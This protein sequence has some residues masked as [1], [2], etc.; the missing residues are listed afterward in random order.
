MKITIQSLSSVALLSTVLLLKSAQVSAQ[1]KIGSNPATITSN[2]NLEVEATNGSKTVI[3]KNNGFIGVNT[4]APTALVDINTGTTTNGLLLGKADK[5]TAVNLSADG[6]VTIKRVGASQATA[7]HIGGFLNLTGM[8]NSDGWRLAQYESFL[9]LAP[10]NANSMATFPFYVHNNG[11][12]SMGTSEKYNTSQL[13]V[14]GKISA[15]GYGTRNGTGGTLQSNSFNIS[16][17]DS[18][19]TLW[20]DN[21]P[22]GVITTTAS[23][24]RL[25]KNVSTIATPALA[26]VKQLRPVNFEYKDIEGDIFKSDNIHHEGFIAHELQ[27]VIPSAVNGEKDALTVDGKIQPQSVNAVPIVAILTQAIQELEAKVAK[28]ETEN[29]QLKTTVSSLNSISNKITELETKLASLN[30]SFSDSEDKLSK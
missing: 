10:L 4:T 20:I 5:S 21:T 12:I 22:L 19:G 3:S 7:P 18:K 2:T 25:K 8:A 27:S 16:V 9:G 1:V 14:N 26:R 28:L 29:G 23:D 17:A 24:Y 11:Q 13:S 6:G 15:V 30:N